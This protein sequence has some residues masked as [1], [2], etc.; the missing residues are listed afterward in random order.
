MSAKERIEQMAE[1]LTELAAAECEMLAGLTAAQLKEIRDEAE[2]AK[3]DNPVV[4]RRLAGVLVEAAAQ[5]AMDHRRDGG[6]KG[7][8][9]A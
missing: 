3:R 5:A 7:E 8:G 2:D 1:R 4:S 6:P 9:N